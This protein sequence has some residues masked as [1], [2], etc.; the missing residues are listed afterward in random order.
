LAG[1]FNVPAVLSYVVAQEQIQDVHFSTFFSF[2]VVAAMLV[3]K[4]AFL[5]ESK[6]VL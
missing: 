5:K 2:F 1:F 4:I 6:S 3:L